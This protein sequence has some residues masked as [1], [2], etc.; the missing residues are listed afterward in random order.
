MGKP[1]RNTSNYTPETINLGDRSA[2]SREDSKSK[3]RLSLHSLS[4]SCAWLKHRGRCNLLWRGEDLSI[5]SERKDAIFAFISTSL[6]DHFSSRPLQA[7]LGKTICRCSKMHR[8]LRM[9]REISVSYLS[10]HIMTWSP[11]DSEINSLID[12]EVFLGDASMTPCSQC[13]RALKYI[14]F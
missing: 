1:L 6:G 13:Y 12:I 5:A 2:T 14:F 7:R 8:C 3:L 11:W 9:L 10:P 4:T